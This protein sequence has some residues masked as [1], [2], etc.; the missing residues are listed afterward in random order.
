VGLLE[1]QRGLSERASEGYPSS[2]EGLDLD[3]TA[4]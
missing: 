4:P 3:M 2:E 1:D